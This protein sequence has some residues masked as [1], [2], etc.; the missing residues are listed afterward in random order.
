[1][2]KNLNDCIGLGR[3]IEDIYSV[4]FLTPNTDKQLAFAYPPSS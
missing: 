3:I 1:M 4:P 2:M